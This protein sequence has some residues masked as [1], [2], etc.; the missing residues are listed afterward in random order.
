MEGGTASSVSAA[1]QQNSSIKNAY[2]ANCKACVW[3]YRTVVTLPPGGPQAHTCVIPDTRVSARAA[4]TQ[5]KYK[6]SSSHLLAQ[7]FERRRPPH[8]LLQRRLLL[9]V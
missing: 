4:H 1:V 7:D 8:S 3:F 9:F 2:G 5:N 6:L